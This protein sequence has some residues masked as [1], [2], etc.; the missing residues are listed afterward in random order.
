M[1]KLTITPVQRKSLKALAHY[2]SPVVMIGGDGLTPAVIKEAKLAISHHGLIKIR[3]FGDDREARVSMYEELC[4]KLG[5]APIQLI[6]KLLVIWRPKDVVDAALLNLSRSGKQ[7]KKTLQAPRTKRQPNR[8]VA[9]K[10]GI[11][12]STSE[13]SERR[14][15]A[16]KSPFTRA[17]A[18]KTPASSTAPKKRVLRAD[19]AESKIGWSSPGYR[20]ATAAPAPIKKR[21]VRM[22]STKK[23]SLGS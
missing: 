5:A 15:A 12:T 8:T 4:D 13:R 6:G 9:I 11:R 18:V 7:T 19:A 21:K 17:A 22:S 16:S 2:L 14:S 10:T 23:K 3:V 1:T 20:K